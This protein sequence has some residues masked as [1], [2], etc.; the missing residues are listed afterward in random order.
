VRNSPLPDCGG[1]SGDGKAWV[2][3][4]LLPMRGAQG[5]E[6][7]PYRTARRTM[8]S[9]MGMRGWH[10]HPAPDE[11]TKDRMVLVEDNPGQRIYEVDGQQVLHNLATDEW[12]VYE[13]PGS[14][15]A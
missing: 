7:I 9:F 10:K 12:F 4:Q 8:M 15:E 14:A 5:T 11:S 1:L 13:E 2:E 3:S 6:N